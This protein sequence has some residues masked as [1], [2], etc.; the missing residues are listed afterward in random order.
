MSEEELWKNVMF[1][2][3]SQN[4][5]PICG[6]MFYRR[7]DSGGVWIDRCIVNLDPNIPNWPIVLDRSLVG[8]KTLM[9]QFPEL[10]TLEILYI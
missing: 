6:Y 4:E 5:E 9:E 2:I 10:K 7:R 8:Y 3:V 1:S